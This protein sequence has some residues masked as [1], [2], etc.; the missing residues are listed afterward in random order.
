MEYIIARKQSLNALE[1][2]INEQAKEGFK[3][4]SGVN[5]TKWGISFQ[6]TIIMERVK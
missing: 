2:E 4:I 3:P 6:Y 5:G 1:K